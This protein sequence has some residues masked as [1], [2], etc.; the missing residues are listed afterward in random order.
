[1]KQTLPMLDR[2]EG[3]ANNEIALLKRGAGPFTLVQAILRCDMNRNSIHAKRPV[4]EHCRGWRAML[5]CSALLCLL[6]VTAADATP[7]VTRENGRVLVT[8]TH[9]R[10][11]FTP[12]LAGFE[13]QIKSADGQWT[14][15][16]EKRGD[17]TLAFFD[18]AEHPARGQRATWALAQK[19]DYVA[20]GQRALLR[21]EAEI[22]LDLHLICMDGGA[23]LGARLVSHEAIG[24][25]HLWCPPRIRLAPDEWDRYLFWAPDR[26]TRA[27]QLAD[28]DP[29][30]SYAGVSAWEQRGDTV[31]RFCKE[32]PAIVVQSQKR[33]A[34]FGVV[35]VDYAGQWPRSHAFI[36]RHTPSALY[37][38]GGYS[39][40]ASAG[41]TRWAWLAPFPDADASTVARQVQSLV[42]VGERL[43][44]SFRPI[45]P[46]IPESWMEDLPDFPAE[47]RRTEPV[48]DIGDAV[49]F[50]IN[51]YTSSDYAVD[52]AKKIGSDCLIRG[53]FKW[54]DAPRVDRWK[55]IP[56]RVHGLGA[57]F[58]GGITCSAL[59]DDEN[60]I[61]H[62]QL[63]NM[64]TR[65]PA[66][67]LIE[68]WDHSGIRHG[69]LS[70]PAYLDYLFRWCREQ[71]DAGADYLFMDEHT[72]V[73]NRMEG[74]DDHSLRDFRE[75][76]LDHCPNTRGW[77]LQDPRWNDRLGI[78]L[79]DR[80]LCP[81]GTI[82][83]LDYRAFMQINDV[84][85][86]PT[87]PSNSLAGLWA[88]FRSWRD[89][90][91]WKLLTDRIRA[92]AKEKGRTVLISANGIAKYVDLQVLGVWGNWVTHDGHIDLSE[93]Q[94]PIWR[95]T[96]KRGH[97]VAGR[98]VPVVLFHDW[99]F[100]DP[101]FPFL[102]VPPSE[103]EIWMRVRGAEIYGAG[104]Y[105]AFP[106]LGPFGC[107]AKRDGTLSVIRQQTAFYQKHRELYLRGRYAGSDAI[108]SDTANLTLA[109]WQL[110]DPRVLLLH[111]INRNVRSGQIRP[112]TDVTVRV[113]VN[114]IPDKAEIISPDSSGTRSA[115]CRVA[116]GNL[117]VT[118]PE[119]DAYSVCVLRFAVEPD[120]HHLTDPMRIVPV[121]R[122]SRP[123]RSEFRVQAG[124]TVEHEGEL[125]GFVQ[126]MLHTHLRN[127]PTFLVNAKTEGQLR[128]RV[129]AVATQ[130]ARLEYR[131]DGQTRQ[132]VDLPDLDNENDGA[133]R[134]YDKVLAFPIP[135]GQHRLTLDNVGADWLTL[136]WL[137]WQ[138]EFL[139]H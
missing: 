42:T 115:K 37:L 130:G 112:L 29:C 49:V 3:W 54:R 126:G 94:L 47:L 38:Y 81:D 6:S 30:P 71:I 109:A 45:S 100:G 125:N 7:A 97:S 59:Y 57:L 27:G 9:Y 1:M 78:D 90:R 120:L 39:P 121:M 96:V 72:A 55:D 68:A 135:L 76:L 88:E 26:T 44:P 56:P 20:I 101:P 124:G 129:R 128:I 33:N 102:A 95:S 32:R 91:A 99:G 14:D 12:E 73:L 36:Q 53:W 28:L 85:E 31:A 64:A 117:E 23:L 86:D 15:V 4:Y 114:H 118:L 127:P 107:D 5:S 19:A 108:T 41:E 84:H 18:G 105:F 134:E 74:Y 58:G 24:G 16:A 111:A 138:G 51:E 75:Y 25:G 61:S 70:S 67:E 133:A 52:V 116:D 17:L 93:S 106:V 103:R 66:G 119:L 113:P 22:V 139:A 69:S 46:P 48:R 82:E 63:L 137:E 79:G 131:I 43:A 11:A 60:G 87:S 104:A 77:S 83:S 10:V 80:R 132:T 13:F 8:G 34:G 123:S 92:Y 110:D 2:G 21:S 98:R 50:T 89:D 35:F 122:W 40:A 62:V 65:G 136:S